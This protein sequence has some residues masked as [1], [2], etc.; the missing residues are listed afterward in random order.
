V[1]SGGFG[2]LIVAGIAVQVVN[3]DALAVF[4]GALKEVLKADVS[5][6]ESAV[7]IL[8]AL[9]L[10]LLPYY[11]PAL[12]YARSPERAAKQLRRMS[13]WILAHSRP[14]EIVVGLAFGIGFLAKG[15]PAL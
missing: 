8:F 3:F 7:A 10:M 13:E 12:I 1:A 11:A 14:L 4:A 6:P 9:A 2:T 15:I 5:V